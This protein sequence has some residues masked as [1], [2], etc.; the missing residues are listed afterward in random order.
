MKMSLLSAQYPQ[1]SAPDLAG[2]N[3]TMANLRQSVAAFRPYL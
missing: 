2:L 1:Y 3:P